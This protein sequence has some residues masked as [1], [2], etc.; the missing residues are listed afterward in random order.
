MHGDLD[1]TMSGP[2]HQQ[3]MQERWEKCSHNALRKFKKQEY[4]FAAYVCGNC[5]TI[6]QVD[7]Y[8]EPKT[9]IRIEPMFDRRPPWGTRLR[10]A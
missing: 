2:T 6:F 5:S 9:Y 4:P 3:E 1:G 8:E 7:R 10:Q